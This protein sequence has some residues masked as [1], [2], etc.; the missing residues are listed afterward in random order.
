MDDIRGDA[1]FS[2]DRKLRHRLDRWWSDEPR[3]LIC[4][5][6]PSDAGAERNDPTIHNLIRLVRPLPGIGGFTVV[7]WEPYIATD[8]KD[9]H[10][11]RAEVD[12]RWLADT[13]GMNL[14]LIAALSGPAAIRIVAWG[15][16]VPQGP[17]TTQ[18]QNA[19]S[20][21]GLYAL[22][23]FGFTKSGR[24]KHPMARGKSR[25][26]NGTVPVIWRPSLAVPA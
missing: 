6:N 1:L 14:A 26:S 7:N 11:W 8:P 15:D 12:L 9:L 3:A 20:L 23:A 17:H 22:Q 10:R 5:A 19:M 25:I 4:M 18:T 16:I 24:P 13:H 2:T 21:N